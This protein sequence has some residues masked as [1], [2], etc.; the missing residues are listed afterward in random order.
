MEFKTRVQPRESVKTVRKEAALG[1]T[2]S[3]HAF[4][5]TLTPL[6]TPQ[7]QTEETEL[8]TEED[9]ADVASEHVTL[10]TSAKELRLRRDVWNVLKGCS[11]VSKFVGDLT[12]AVFGR[13]YCGTHSL[14]GKRSSQTKDPTRPVKPA[15]DRLT[16]RAITEVAEQLFPGKKVQKVFFSTKF[17]N[18]DKLERAL[19]KD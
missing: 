2:I 10:K 5:K 8:A 7:Q 1:R 19:F 4:L 6:H 9:C 12:E 13:D 16:I 11:S 3:D 14:S 15:A 17:N 18:V